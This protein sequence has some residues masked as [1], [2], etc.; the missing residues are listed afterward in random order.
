MIVLFQT[1]ALLFARCKAARGSRRFAPLK[2]FRAGA[3]LFGGR[4]CR[5][6]CGLGLA[7]LPLPGGLLSATEINVADFNNQDSY[8]NLSG[9]NGTFTGKSAELQTAFDTAVFHGAYGASFR[10]DY[11][12]SNGFCGIWHSL[13]GKAS[14]PRYTL[15]LTNL[16]EGLKNSTGNPSRVERVRATRFSFWARG[17]GDSLFDHQ[18]KVE[19]KS[20]E[21]V[22]ASAV[23]SVPNETNWIRCDFPL[24]D[25][26]TNDLS[27]V[28]EVVLV[29][30]DWRNDNRTGRLYLDDLSFTTDEPDYNPALWPDDALLDLV[31]QRAF[32]Y[33]M[34]YTDDLGFALDRSTYSD[35]VSTGTI[36][37]Q[38]AAYC[39]GHR[40]G[41]AD[42][43]D[44]EGRVTS[45][46]RNL[47]DLP[48]GP[49]EGTACSG[50]RG[51]YYHFLAANTGLRKDAGVELSLYDTMLLMNG[52]LACRDYFVTN[53]QIQT[54]SREL[55]DRVE[56]DWFVDR[57]PGMN[58]NRFHLSWQP[59]P[60]PEGTFLK[61]V[62]GQ[63]DEAFMVDVLALGSRTHP[64]SLETYL[65]R[66][67]VYGSYPAA[68]RDAILASWRGSMFNYFFASCWLDFKNRGTDLHPASP[69]NLWQNDRLAILANRAFC[70]DHA[71]ADGAPSEDHYATY[72]PNA[73]G[74]TACDNLV[75]PSSGLSSEYFA[76]GALPTEENIRFGTKAFQAGTLAVYGAVSS[77]NFVPELS[78]A[79]LRHYIGIPRLWSPLSGLADAFSLDPHT[80]G[81]PYD[82]DGNPTIR[83]AEYLNGPWINHTTMGINVGPMLLAIENYRS[84]FLW[85][86]A[87]SCPEMSSGLNAIFGASSPRPIDITFSG[88]AD[89]PK[90]S[91]HWNPEPGISEY[92]IF[93][94]SDLDHWQLREKSVKGTNWT[95]SDAGP[96][97]HRF[98]QVKGIR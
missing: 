11:S 8:N 80:V 67:R 52:V 5:L 55:F 10:M 35:M 3:S 42:R 49:D 79:A 74:L 82:R 97:R 71:A 56:W 9:D 98:Y 33:F 26:A 95:D 93:T 13:S 83:S 39:V 31:S 88:S 84:G 76:F 36:G 25:A 58:S 90:V 41:W 92:C 86:L 63:T 65:S 73:W 16:Y 29:I 30:E 89:R 64:I 48:M 68:S 2:P 75:A 96:P 28:K 61:H 6:V 24:A 15:N 18:I 19:L 50:C 20:P 77:I 34:R 72:G 21:R 17:D 87:D 53:T 32:F 62:D 37:F 38:L 43:A 69:C 81:S 91:L 46:L 59:G 60:K 70:I 66:N 7:C 54:L 23:F 85:N 78:V 47:M 94:S 14:Y 4:L 40:R 45:I 51:F 57:S 12:V 22:V 27:R 44:L 1:A